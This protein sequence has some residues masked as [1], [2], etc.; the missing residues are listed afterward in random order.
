MTLNTE[1]IE[2]LTQQGIEPNPGFTCQAVGCGKQNGRYSGDSCLYCKTKRSAKSLSIRLGQIE[3]SRTKDP[4]TGKN[5]ESYEAERNAVLVT[6]FSRCDSAAIDRSLSSFGALNHFASPLAAQRLRKRCPPSHPLL[7][8]SWGLA[9]PEC[10]C[11]M[12]GAAF[13]SVRQL[14]SLIYSQ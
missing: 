7:V 2:D 12:E 10:L 6:L 3:G 13:H 1:W 11:A 5:L 9:S 8:T 4:K 14:L